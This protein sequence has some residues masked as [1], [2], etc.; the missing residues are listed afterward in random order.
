M[1]IPDNLLKN[2]LP[3]VT[4]KNSRRCLICSDDLQPGTIFERGHIDNNLRIC[5]AG[6][7]DPMTALRMVTLNAAECY[8][9]KDRG[10][11]A[12]G[13]RADIVLA[14]DL[15]HF[16]INKVFSRG[17]PVAENG[18]YLPALSPCLDF[19]FQLT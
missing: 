7:L 1:C 6:G 15:K 17:K 19:M 13:L 2:L 8:G 11:F 5:I 10:G 16:K 3:G 14:G 12:P 18:I 9:M 4:E